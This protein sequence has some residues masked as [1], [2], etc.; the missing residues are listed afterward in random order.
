MSRA[1]AI[2]IFAAAAFGCATPAPRVER[3]QL[4]LAVEVTRD[5][6]VLGTPQVL[7]F[8]GKAITVERRRPG[9]AVPDYRL[10]L[11]PRAT[12]DGYLYGVRLEAAGANGRGEV[13][14]LH[15][16]ERSV[17]LDEHLQLKV[18]LM[19]VDSPE[20]KTWI[21]TKPQAPGLI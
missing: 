7:G 11:S 13:G 3:T 2:A 6:V 17:R 21:Q 18:L 9:A 4:Y 8:A 14:L 16:E 15:G 10:E 19:E 12:P 5:G 20:F 1:L